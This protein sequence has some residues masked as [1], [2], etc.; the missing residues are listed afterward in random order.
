M[1]TDG[2]KYMKSA[3][4]ILKSQKNATLKLLICTFTQTMTRVA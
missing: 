2:Q 3:E 1:E 4:G